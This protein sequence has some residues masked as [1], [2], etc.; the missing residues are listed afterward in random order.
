MRALA[1]RVLQAEIAVPSALL[2]G[3]GLVLWLAVFSGGLD[4]I[5]P[6]LHERRDGEMNGVW[7]ARF[8]IDEIRSAVTNSEPGQTGLLAGDPTSVSVKY[9]ERGTQ[10]PGSW[11][12]LVEGPLRVRPN[13]PEEFVSPDGQILVQI[14]AFGADIEEFSAGR[15][16]L[17]ALDVSPDG[18][19]SVPLQLV[20]PPFEVWIRL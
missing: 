4:E 13:T 20:W 2:I 1:G 6:N 18:F 15:G 16:V 10:R 12:V 14:R 7:A 17:S 9:L 11:I 5:P 8:A 19:A 3:F